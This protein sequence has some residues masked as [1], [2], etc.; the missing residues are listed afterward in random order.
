MIGRSR[1]RADSRGVRLFKYSALGLIALAV[2]AALIAFLYLR[3]EKFNRYLAIEV[4]KAL[5]SY[6]LRAEIE[7][8]EPELGSGA[9]TLRDV[10]L[11]NQ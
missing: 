5:E 4:E 9:V 1:V 11:F 2:T 10:K 3:S 8:V 7:K 6:G